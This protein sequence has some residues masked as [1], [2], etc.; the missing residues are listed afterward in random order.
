[1]NADVNGVKLWML[2]VNIC[3]SVNKV[4]I[5]SYKCH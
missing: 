1:M 3:Y 2:F 4:S 5:F